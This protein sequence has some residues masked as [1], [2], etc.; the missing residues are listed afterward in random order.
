MALTGAAVVLGCLMF[1]LEVQVC[2]KKQPES[3]GDK[4][5]KQVVLQVKFNEFRSILLYV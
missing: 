2:E 1:K 3:G 4:A 5:R